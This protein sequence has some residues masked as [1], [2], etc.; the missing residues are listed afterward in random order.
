MP[1]NGRTPCQALLGRQPHLLAPFEGG[2]FGD[3]DVNGQNNLA[4]VRDIAVVSIIEPTA[5]QRLAR[6]DKRNMI[7][8]METPE[9]KPGDLVD[10]WYD[11]P[12]KG[13][14]GWRGPAQIATVNK[15][16]GNITVR[17]QGET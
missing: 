14:P 1:I 5:K 17:S 11:P 12:R 10:I 4:R 6:G 15:G 2:Y 9:H 7:A 13:T 3:F 8:A 16:G